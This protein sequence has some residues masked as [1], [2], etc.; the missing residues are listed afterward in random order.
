[1]GDVCTKIGSGC[2]GEEVYPKDGPYAFIRSQNC[3]QLST[4]RSCRGGFIG[5]DKHA[6][7]LAAMSKVENLPD[8]VLFTKHHGDICRTCVS[9]GPFGRLPARVNQHVTAIIR[10]N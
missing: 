4:I 9:G 7:A 3:V 10:P 8:D 6:E 5:D 1:M 2:G